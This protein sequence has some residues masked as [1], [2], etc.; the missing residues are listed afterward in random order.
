LKGKELTPYDV[1]VHKNHSQCAEYLKLHGAKSATD[2]QTGQEKFSEDEAKRYAEMAVSGEDIEDLDG[3]K[4]ANI[5][6]EEANRIL[7]EDAKKEEDDK[8]RIDLE[9]KHREAE[10]KKLREENRRREEE[11]IKL[12]EEKKVLEEEKRKLEEDKRRQDAERNRNDEE[13]KKLEKEN[14]RIEKEKRYLQEEE[15]RIKEFNLFRE[16]ESRRIR[17]AQK[18]IE[19]QN[20]KSSEENRRM[21]RE[22]TALS[23]SLVAAAIATAKLQIRGEQEQVRNYDVTL[24]DG[25]G[26]RI[27]PSVKLSAIHKVWKPAKKRPKKVRKDTKLVYNDHASTVYGMTSLLLFK[28][29]GKNQKSS[30]ELSKPIQNDEISNAKMSKSTLVYGGAKRHEKKQ[31]GKKQNNSIKSRDGKLPRIQSLMT[32]ESVA[33]LKKDCYS[34][35]NNNASM[36]YF[37]GSGNG[38]LVAGGLRY[39]NKRT[40]IQ[41]LV[42]VFEAKRIITREL[43]AAKRRRL[44]N[45][46]EGDLGE[47]LLVR[48]LVK[49]YQTLAVNID[50]CNDIDFSD[51]YRF[52]KYLHGRFLYALK[53]FDTITPLIVLNYCHLWNYYNPQS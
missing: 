27:P 23:N 17:D 7:E 37:L 52:Q 49:E 16:E 21:E 14:K 46:Y 13:R 9:N 44:Y 19:D 47:E 15:K 26:R 24:E 28:P 8:L 50:K 36:N 53:G 2:C 30:V 11:R 12:E 32:Q 33:C 43:H 39:F 41:E 6:M 40:Y 1:A 25:N 34:E 42:R 38:L 45:D 51:M 22:W 35:I 20:R 5:K 4:Q 18:Q 31:N 29:G 3:R 48:Q 10:R